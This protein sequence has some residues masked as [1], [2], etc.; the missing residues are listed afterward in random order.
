LHNFY[1]IL[2]YHYSNGENLEKAEEYLIKAGE[3][4]LKSSASSEAI[5]FYQEGLKL[6]LTK[7]G[8]AA[9]SDKLAMFEKNIALAFFNKGQYANALEYFDRVLKRLGERSS[10]NQII[11]AYRLISDFLN[12]IKNLYLPSKK[13]I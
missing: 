1:G 9:D 13:A 3:E 11:I 12:L 6:Y 5:N 10:K 4:A 2:A 7:Y 8:D